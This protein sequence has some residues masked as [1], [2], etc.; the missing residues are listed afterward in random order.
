[1]SLIRFTIVI[2]AA[3]HRHFLFQCVRWGRNWCSGRWEPCVWKTRF[4]KWARRER[5]GRQQRPYWWD[6]WSE[7]KA[8]KALLHKQLPLSV[9]LSVCQGVYPAQRQRGPVGSGEAVG[10]WHGRFGVTTKWASASEQGLPGLW[11]TNSQCGTHPS[12][13][14]G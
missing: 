14:L 2:T 4:G 7:G 3:E 13:A 1:M 12:T 6:Y 9:C 5:G 10:T 8:N 11:W